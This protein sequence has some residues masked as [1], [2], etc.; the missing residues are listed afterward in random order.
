[1]FGTKVEEAASAI[2]KLAN[3][4]LALMQQRHAATV[5]ARAAEDAAGDA[6]LD[7]ETEGQPSPP[8]DAVVKATAEIAAIDGGLRACRARRLQAVKTKR[9]AEAAAL[10]KQAG[11]LRD[12]AAAIKMRVAQAITLVNSL[13]ATEVVVSRRG[14]VTFPFRRGWK[15]GRTKWSGGPP[16]W[17]TKCHVWGPWTS[18]TPRM[19]S[20]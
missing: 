18:R 7:G 12:Q 4:E 9:L 8:V 16:P 13:E 2:E 17:R 6:F 1:M 10:R 19:W 3:R 11:E 14:P 15:P 5:K 20:R